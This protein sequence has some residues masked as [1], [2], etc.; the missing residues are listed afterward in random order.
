MIDEEINRMQIKGGEMTEPE[1]IDNPE[2]VLN[3]LFTECD[4]SGQITEGGISRENS[5]LLKYFSPVLQE[6]L[7]GL[8]KGDSIVF[9]IKE[10]LIIQ[11]LL[12]D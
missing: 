4:A 12:V 2:N 6:K 3:V 11:N 8:K 5:V 9:K 10:A 7:K 1:V